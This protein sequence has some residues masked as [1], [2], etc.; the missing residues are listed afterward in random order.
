MKKTGA[1]VLFCTFFSLFSQ[2]VWPQDFSSIDQDLAQLESLINDTL[3]NTI[4]Q[5]KLLEDLKQNLDESGNLIGNYERIITERENLL[6]DLQTQLNAMYE[7][8]RKQSA[9][10]AKYEK[11]SK[12]WRT[13]TLIAIPVT[14]IISGSVVWAAT[15]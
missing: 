5:Q 1:F 6:R 3:Q 9:L 15:R 14:A 12:F 2:A 4:E 7:T 8:Y 13:F 10:S 11:N